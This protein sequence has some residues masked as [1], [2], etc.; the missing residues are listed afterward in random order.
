MLI[1]AE[2]S[3]GMQW[4]YKVLPMH[5]PVIALHRCVHITDEHS[6]Y[7]VLHTN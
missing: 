1:K 7:L 5:R 2:V 4:F 3:M 6:H